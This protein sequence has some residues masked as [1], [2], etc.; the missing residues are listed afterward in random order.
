MVFK[1]TQNTQEKPQ[2]IGWNYRNVVGYSSEFTKYTISKAMVIPSR[3]KVATVVLS[4]A[5][6]ET[7]RVW[8]A[9]VRGVLSVQLHRTVQVLGVL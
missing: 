8:G 4:H 7:Q 3:P 6:P 2:R 5:L 9:G 1:S